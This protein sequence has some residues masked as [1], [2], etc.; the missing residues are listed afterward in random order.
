MQ[1]IAGGFIIFLAYEGF[2]LIANSAQ[3]AREPRRVLPRAYYS[4][5]LFV[6]ALYVLVAIVTVG[7]LP[8]AQIVKARDYALAAAAKPFMGSAGFTLITIA[9]LLSTASAI[10]ATL[11]GA[12]RLSYIIAVEGEIPEILERKIWN[13]PILGLLITTAL[14]LVVA[15]LFDL[16]SISTMGS[17]GFLL[18]FA[19]V[20]VANMRLAKKTDSRAWQSLFGAI[21]CILALTAL[22]WQTALD[23]PL[24]ILILVVMLGLSF[25]IEIIFRAVKKPMEKRSGENATKSQN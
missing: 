24:K 25:G 21:A 3:D 16:S 8:V 20:N 14:T 5:V 19:A 10:N 17:S 12:A 15:N 11:Y 18:I 2:E 6:I 22:I 1:L 13:Q 7:N 4:A 9:A 23:A